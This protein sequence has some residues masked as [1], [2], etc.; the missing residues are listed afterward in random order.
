MWWII[1]GAI[2]AILVVVFIMIWFK[3]TGTK[4]FDN[5]GDQIDGFGDCDKD[6]VADVFDKCPCLPGTKEGELSGCPGG[7]KE[8]KPCDDNE[9]KSCKECGKTTACPTT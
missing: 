5:V 9:L 3:G 4:A 1:V 2:L 6:N 8:A 7:Q